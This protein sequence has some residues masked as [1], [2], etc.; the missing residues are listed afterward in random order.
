MK[1]V[2]HLLLVFLS[3]SAY[4]QK[5]P[6]EVGSSMSI[7][8]QAENAIFSNCDSFLLSNC[9][10]LEKDDQYYSYFKEISNKECN[11][12]ILDRNEM[13]LLKNELTSSIISLINVVATNQLYFRDDKINKSEEIE[14]FDLVSKSS[15]NAILFNPKF[16][17]C[18]YNGSKR[19]IVYVEKEKFDNIQKNYFDAT[20]K[21]S[22]Q[23]LEEYEIFKIKNP[24][25]QFAEEL[26]QLN[27]F[28]NV[29]RSF[30]SLMV[31]LNIDEKTLDEYLNLEQRVA[32]FESS[33]NN[34]ENNLIHV[35]EYISTKNYI[36]AYNLIRE[37]KL[38]FNG[39]EQRKILFQK[40]KEYLDLV[41]LEKN[42]RKKEFKNNA[43]SFN[44]LSF[45]FNINTALVNNSTNSSGEMNY[46][47]NSPFD[48]LYPALG[49]RFIFN[50]RDKKWGIGPY[51]KQHFSNYLISLNNIEYYFPFSKN[52]S[53]AGV[54]GQYF[55]NS[56][57]ITFSAAKLLGKYQDINQ[58]AL[59]FWTFS[60][61]FKIEFQKTSF[62]ASLILT[63]A[64]SE[65]SFNG[66]SF[67]ISYDL[68]LNR[69]IS[70][71]QLRDLENEFPDNF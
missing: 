31:T 14:I 12:Y 19:I 25:Y 48:R 1:R 35:D 51:Y 11:S 52:F 40:Q 66:F 43:S 24:N 39:V 56:T 41:R 42:R 44:K 54:W 71:S 4:G 27:S 18:D 36:S 62:Y 29:L 16:T 67:G 23:L 15:S 47:Y 13:S 22:K 2:A 38:R 17:F 59:N 70:D 46:T 63:R 10:F 58:S 69:K 34:L 33:L 8:N 32:T 7:E 65:Y 68:K 5:N 26:E 28:L 20:I 37:L 53:E 45:D 49:V 60:P 30:Y 6:L 21:I 64:N 61:G 50:D 9:I 55:I 57:S 3:F